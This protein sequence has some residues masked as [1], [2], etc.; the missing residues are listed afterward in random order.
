MGTLQRREPFFCP[1]LEALRNER[2]PEWGTSVADPWVYLIQINAGTGKRKGL[3]DGDMIWVENPVGKRIKGRARL[4][5]GVHDEHV[6]IAGCHGHWA[7]GMPIA[8]RKGVF[9]D[10]LTLCDIHYTDSLTQGSDTCV[11]VKIYKCEEG[12]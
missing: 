5:E 7:K 2:A 4:V 11:K 1:R 8:E 12:R 6:C 3:K 9:F 10:N